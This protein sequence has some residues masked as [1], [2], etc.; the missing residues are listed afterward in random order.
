MLIFLGDIHG[1]FN[2][3][4]WQIETNKI[5]DATIIQVG[6][7]GIGFTNENNRFNVFYTLLYLVKKLFYKLKLQI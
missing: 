5:I 2:N 4:K 3:L 6:D 7:F 1:N